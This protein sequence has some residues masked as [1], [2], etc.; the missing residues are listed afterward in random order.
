MARWDLALPMSAQLISYP[1]D[2][3]EFGTSHYSKTPDDDVF[4][5]LARTYADAHGIMANTTVLSILRTHL[6]PLQRPCGGYNEFN[7]GVVNG[8]KWFAFFG[9][10]AVLNG[11]LN[12]VIT[13]SKDW[14][15][16]NTNEMQITVELSC[17]HHPEA[18]QLEEEWNTNK[19]PL[20]EYMGKVS[21]ALPASSF[22]G[23]LGLSRCLWY[24]V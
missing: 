3:T 14:V 1:F 24:C 18:S 10:M 23:H 17:C 16:L 15:Y 19:D 13:C 2:S 6:M 11:C 22:T 4:I 7:Q 20:L 9:S 12:P 5:H 8:A 21:L